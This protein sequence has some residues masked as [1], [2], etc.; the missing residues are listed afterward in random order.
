MSRTSTQ[1]ADYAGVHKDA[2]QIILQ[3]ECHYSSG[4]CQGPDPL[5]GMGLQSSASIGGLHLTRLS[6]EARP[7][8]LR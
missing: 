5:K 1:N 6:E 4:E 8:K 2:S 7:P 3:A